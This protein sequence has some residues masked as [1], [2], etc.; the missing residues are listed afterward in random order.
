[1]TLLDT[2]FPFD[3]NDPRKFG[4]LLGQ[5]IIALYTIEL[6]I[7]YEFEK[8]G[9]SQATHHNLR[10]LFQRLPIERRSSVERKYSEI[11]E[12]RVDWTF[13]IARS[14]HSLLN[15]LG[16]E[17]ITNTRYF[18]EP[19]RAH[20]VDH[21]SILIMP[22]ILRHLLYSMLIALHDYP[23]SSLPKR[24]N[25]TFVSLKRSLNRDKQQNH[26][27]QSKSRDESW[28]PN[29]VWME[30]MLTLFE[31]KF[32]LESE[33]HRRIG[34]D[35]GR[36]IISLYLVEVILKCAFDDPRAIRHA[37]HNLYKLF[38]SL[39]I[40]KIA[41][42]ERTYRALLNS[43]KEWEWD[44]ADSVESLLKYLGKTAFT[45]TRYFW[46]PGRTHI[47]SFSSILVMPNTIG[48]LLYALFIS[49]HGYPSEP[50]EKRF[51]TYFQSLEESFNEERMLA[52][53]E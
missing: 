53:K 3:N 11:L 39:S 10:A 9:L 38:N 43:S 13:D 5:Q 19:G 37:R 1:M 18:W 17:P 41:N 23:C 49:L 24:Y 14:V 50:L 12:N 40:E 42:C 47:A 48:N 44:I 27:R 15:Y 22:D 51:D 32:P 20:L 4:F 6:I 52:R 31:A 30:G 25:T 29:I 35:V 45:D 8:L 21:A 34:F 7:K 2:P 36:Q 28:K 33:D 46:D 26:R 16:K